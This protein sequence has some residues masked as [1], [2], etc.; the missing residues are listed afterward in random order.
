[1][2]PAVDDLSISVLDYRNRIVEKD[3]LA[4]N[5]ARENLFRAQKKMKDYYNQNTKKNVFEV[6]QRVWVYTLRTRKGLSKNL[7]HNSLGIV[8]KLSPVHFKLGTITN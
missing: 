3:E 5:L 8:E 7:M 4:Q 1:M 2:P 6:G